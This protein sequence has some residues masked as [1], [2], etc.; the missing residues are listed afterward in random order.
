MNEKDKDFSR[1]I[2]LGSD[3]YCRFNCPSRDLVWFQRLDEKVNLVMN[4]SD[5]EHDPNE[6][7]RKDFSEIAYEW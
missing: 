4:I 3:N 5:L 2:I 6:V 1:K 7:Q